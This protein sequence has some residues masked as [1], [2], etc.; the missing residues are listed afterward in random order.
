MV[1]KIATG[2][3]NTPSHKPFMNLTV[4]MIPFSTKS[5]S[6][7][8]GTVDHSTQLRINFFEA[9]FWSIYRYMPY[10]AVSVSTQRDADYINE[11][12]LPVFDVFRFEKDG[13]VAWE[14]PRFSL[15]KAHESLS[16]D[17]RWSH[18][19]YLYFTEGDQLLHMRHQT[20]LMKFLVATGGKF[21]LVP[22]RMQVSSLHIFLFYIF[23]HLLLF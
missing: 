7:A 8:A 1:K 11:L 15:L 14:L 9:T 3:P 6:S 16:S 18:F 22:H 4:V 23:I 19:E 17:P 21:A 20:D 5:A 12:Q 10:I 2:I 13:G